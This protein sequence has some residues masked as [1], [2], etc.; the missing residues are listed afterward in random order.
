MSS[1]V[2]DLLL[3]DAAVLT[4]APSG[5][6]QRAGVVALLGDRILHVGPDDA[7]LT[8]KRTV[9]L[10]GRCVVPGFH[11]AHQH[12]AWFGASLDEIDLSTPP[13]RSLDDVAAAV[14]AAARTTPADTWIV[15]NG[16][17]KIRDDVMW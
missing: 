4:M 16:Y 3:T 13:V 1:P 7:G 15:G 9:S 12:M 17:L 11:D 6:A 10:D 14:A 2:A 5:V 8:A